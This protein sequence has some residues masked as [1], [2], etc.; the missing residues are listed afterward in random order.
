LLEQPWTPESGMVTAAFKLKRQ[1]IEATFKSDI[2][3]MYAIV[4]EEFNVPP[5]SGSNKVVPV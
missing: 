5:K 4:N 1:T 2:D 3:R